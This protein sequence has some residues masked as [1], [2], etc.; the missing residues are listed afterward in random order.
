MKKMTV[1]YYVG[2]TGTPWRADL[3]P[4]PQ[5]PGNYK[6]PV[7]IAA[8]IEEKR[9]KQEQTAGRIPIYGKLDSVAV[10]DRAG[11]TLFYDEGSGTGSEATAPAFFK[12]LTDTFVFPCGHDVALFGPGGDEV[13][14]I[15]FDIKAALKMTAMEMLAPMEPELTNRVPL[16]MWHRRTFCVDPFQLLGSGIADFNWSVA[17]NFFGLQS[18]VTSELLAEDRADLA[19]ELA[20]KL[21]LNATTATSAAQTAT[22]PF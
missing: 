10:L 22:A 9:A 11:E 19:F 6:D 17:E 21:G 16:R 8:A 2:W 18:A 14:L 5:A 15:G 4:D 3:M 12:F 20:S 7:K 1:N 13:Q